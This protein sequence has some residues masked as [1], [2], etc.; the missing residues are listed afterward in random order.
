MNRPTM[1]SLAFL[2]ASILVA[3]SFDVA[4]Q[5]RMEKLWVD[6]VTVRDG[7]C[8][9]S[10]LRPRGRYV[11]VNVERRLLSNRSTS[12]DAT[13]LINPECTTRSNRAPDHELKFLVR[14]RPL[15][16]VRVT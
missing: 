5:P 9:P 14:P 4:A 11:I 2:S 3:M 16:R 15:A 6:T 10:T 13:K 1:A 8:M 7:E 12:V